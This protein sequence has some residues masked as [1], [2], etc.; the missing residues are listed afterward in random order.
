MIKYICFTTL[1]RTKN[2]AT[3]TSPYAIL[4]I[5]LFHSSLDYTG[6]L[7]LFILPGQGLSGRGGGQSRASDQLVC[8]WHLHQD[9]HW[10]LLLL[11]LDINTLSSSDD[12][13]QCWHAE[14]DRISLSMSS[15]VE[16]WPPSHGKPMFSRISLTAFIIRRYCT[17]VQI[18]NG[19]V[20][21]DAK[22]EAPASSGEIGK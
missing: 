4:D 20:A 15:F 22:D 18:L 7:W 9:S 12:Q 6:S 19:H 16:R 10:P 21:R 14:G 2:T 1:Y 5:H 13:K 3:F 17:M 11:H 8:F